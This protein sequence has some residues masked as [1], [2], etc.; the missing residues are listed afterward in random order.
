MELPLDGFVILG[1]RQGTT[2][3]F[4]TL[5]SE[6]RQLPGPLRRWRLRSTD[7]GDLVLCDMSTG[8]ECP[9][10]ECF[11]EA[12]VVDPD[13]SSLY[14]HN[15]ETIVDFDEAFGK[16]DPID[17]DVKALGTT[18]S[19]AIGASTLGQHGASM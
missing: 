12:V 19:Q 7:A 5:T 18:V 9:A 14:L 13:S 4:H 17:A 8:E 11:A 6:L 3:M 1:S 15:G 16:F 2:C 10:G